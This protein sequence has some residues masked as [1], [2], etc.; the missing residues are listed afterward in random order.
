MSKIL[1]I[2]DFDRDQ[3]D[4]VDQDAHIVALTPMAMY[5]CGRWGMKYTIPEDYGIWDDLTD[6]HYK[7]R[8]TDWLG[9][10]DDFFN[11]TY[12]LSDYP[13][14][15]VFYCL[16]MLRFL[17]ESF[18][19]KYFSMDLIFKQLTPT[20]VY[21]MIDKSKTRRIQADD[22]LYNKNG[23][24]F[25]TIVSQWSGIA[26][27]YLY[28]KT[29]QKKQ[30]NF[31][32]IPFVRGTYNWFRNYEFLPS[33]NKDLHLCFANIIPGKIQEARK[34]G[35]KVTMLPEWKGNGYEIK[36]VE[37]NYDKF[38]SKIIKTFSS[39][40]NIDAHIVR[41]CLFNSL[42]H[43]VFEVAPKIIR[44]EKAYVDYFQEKK[45]DFSVL[46]YNRRNKPYL[47][48]SLI[49]ANKVGIKTMYIR[50]GWSADEAWENFY[51]RFAPFDYF[52]APSAIDRDFYK[53]RAQEWGVQ[54]QVI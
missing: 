42:Y 18:L 24:L 25:Y 32:D 41:G 8:I 35:H 52:L 54:C 13:M 36:E 19:R 5:E 11:D 9:N 10:V 23:S 50:H 27:T 2:E 26:K 45:D 17:S 40:F 21:Y 43:F 22:D 29:E 30:T 47:Y 44:A 31:K 3:L 48:A 15:F 34:R 4:I 28:T 37:P 12:D 38:D 6:E 49:A 51:T 39:Y 14:P 7:K 46:I 33:W 20:E 53:R 1:F 16:T